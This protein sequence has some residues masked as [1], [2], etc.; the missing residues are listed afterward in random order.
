MWNPLVDRGF[1]NDGEICRP[2]LAKTPRPMQDAPPRDGDPGSRGPA[3]G[4][5]GRFRRNSIARNSPCAVPRGLVKDSL[6]GGVY[7]AAVGKLVLI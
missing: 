1:A 5:L 4:R 7:C 3:R 2:N 6:S